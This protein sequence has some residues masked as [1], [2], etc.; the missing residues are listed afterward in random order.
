MTSL[1]LHRSVPTLT[2]MQ[3]LLLAAAVTLACL[4]VQAAGA[5]VNVS[6]SRELLAA[7][8]DQRADRIVLQKDVAM[9]AEFDQ[10]N[11]SPLQITRCGCHLG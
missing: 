9:D 4:A 1:R 6:S 11:Q 7:L 8:Q 10:F 2:A 5:S 3:L